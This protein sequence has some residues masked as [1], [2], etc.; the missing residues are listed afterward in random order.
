MTGECGLWRDQLR[1]YR[2]RL[3]NHQT[4]LKN[5]SPD[6]CDR[7]ELLQIEHLHNQLHIQLINIHD[8][9]QGIK[10]HMQVIAHELEMSGKISD[11]SIAKH[12][13]L[14]EEYM[15]LKNTLQLVFEEFET[16]ISGVVI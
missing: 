2:S 13:C 4:L 11:N 14:E 12:E 7:D 3:Y 5:S 6:L 8:L 9:K 15:M 10:R 1:S 16:F